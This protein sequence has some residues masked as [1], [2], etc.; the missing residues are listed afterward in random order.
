MGLDRRMITELAEDGHGYHLRI[1]YRAGPAWSYNITWPVLLQ[2]TPEEIE[3]YITANH[4]REAMARSLRRWC[5][6]GYTYRENGFFLGR[7]SGSDL[8]YGEA[9][10]KARQSAWI[11]LS[12]I[13]FFLISTR[14]RP[15]PA[16]LKQS[17]P[18]ILEYL[19]ISRAV[20][21]E[22][23]LVWTWAYEGHSI[24][25]NPSGLDDMD[26]ISWLRSEAAAETPDPEYMQFLDLYDELPF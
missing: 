17:I 9:Y 5:Y 12:P 26:F 10:E 18:T 13:E 1:E 8:S 19:D 7:E 14:R 2:H 23:E 25:C 24:Y 16:S 20:P 4:F 6:S 3:H 22:E 11:G 21:D 15:V